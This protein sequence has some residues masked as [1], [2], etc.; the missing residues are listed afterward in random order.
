MKMKKKQKKHPRS[1]L[2]D[3]LSHQTSCVCTVS[4][5]PNQLKKPQL[6]HSNY[7]TALPKI[8]SFILTKIKA[9]CVCVWF[10]STCPSGTKNKHTKLLPVWETDVCK[11]QALVALS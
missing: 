7:N 1:E 2:Q 5:E 9:V 3:I 8:M 11:I 10:F 4:T 6:K